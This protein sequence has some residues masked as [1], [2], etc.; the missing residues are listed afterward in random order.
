MAIFVRIAAKSVWSFY[1]LTRSTSGFINDTKTSVGV[2]G[3]VDRAREA[4]TQTRVGVDERLHLVRVAG[5]DE[6]EVVAL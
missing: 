6:G 2:V 1:D 4:T 3:E 5:S